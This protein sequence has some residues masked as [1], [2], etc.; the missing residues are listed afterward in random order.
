MIER[1]GMFNNLMTKIPALDLEPSDVIAQTASQAFDISIWQFLTALICGACVDILPDNVA[2]NP[3]ALSAALH[4][5]GIT[6]L[7]SVPA[8]IQAMLDALGANNAAEET[9]LAASDRRSSIS[10]PMSELVRALSKHSN[11]KCIW[12]RRMRR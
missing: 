9:A 12:S 8:M 7:E 11:A 10:C 6:I 1:L 2:Q 3:L 4:N 5:R